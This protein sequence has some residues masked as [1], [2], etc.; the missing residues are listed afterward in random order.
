MVTLK[1]ADNSYTRVT[2]TDSIGRFFFNNGNNV[3]SSII[4]THIGY[5]PYEW[6]FVLS[7]DTTFAV[8]LKQ[9]VKQLSEVR[10]A[11]TRAAIER[12]ADKVVYNLGSS[13]IA[14]G[15]NAFQA[16]SQ[17]SGVQVSN[18]EIS[19][20]GRGV[21]RVM[22]NNRLIQLQGEDL[23][24]YLKS[25]SANQV[26]RIE[27]LTNPSARYEV[28]GNAGLINI[29]TKQSKLQGY[30]G[31]VQL[32]SKYYQSGQS[33]VYGIQTF[34]EFSGSANLAY[35]WNRWSA[36][37]SF[38]HVRDRHLEG[39]QFDLFY[40]KQHWLQTDTGLYTH[41][42]YTAL[43][44][45]DYKLS[46]KAAI[47]AYY[48]GGRDMYDGSDN[49][50]NPIYNSFG[51]VDS[52][53]KTY[54]HYH[55]IA[56]P[57]ALNL[58]ADVKLDTTGKH[59]FINADYF[60]YYRND[61]S[62]FESNSYDAAGNQ[63]SD[64][65]TLYFDRNKQNILIYT[66]KA[67]MEWPTAFATYSFGG[68]L[69]YIAE[70]SNAL[71]YNKTGAVGRVFNTNLSN[72]FSYT[73]NTQSF[74]GSLNKE[75]NKWKLQGGIRGEITQTKGYSYT[76]QKTTIN[77]YVKVF[78]SLLAGYTANPDNILSLVV[79]RRI[80]RPAFWN[81]NPFKSLFTA[82]SYGE[83]NPYLQPEYATNL[84]LSHA[85]KNI[86]RTSLFANKTGNGFVNVTIPHPDTNLVYTIPL[87][88]IRTVRIGITENVTFKLSRWWE[89]SA[90]VSVYHTSAHSSLSNIRSLKG[91]SA[92]FSSTNNLYFNQSK[93]FAAAINFWYQF[94]EVDHIGKTDR[95]YKMDVGFKATTANRKWDIAANL[96]D[97]FRSSAL[98]YSY[99]VNNI[100]QKFTNF[101]IIRYFQ[102]SL[103]YRFGSGSGSSTD[104]NAGN[105][106]E[107]A[108]V[109]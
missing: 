7:H 58:H 60:N 94:P 44:G 57:A 5:E 90:M 26:V 72:E 39:F 61:I 21:V 34:G 52:L 62:D 32:A 23:S 82:Y 78:P 86:L 48:S 9:S 91:E 65:K 88:F 74:Y 89:S 102:L 12:T 45:V 1:E 18:N 84:E 107:R 81:L 10:V 6:P 22:L 40:P 20:V 106:E 56:L 33:S 63:K 46:S 66:L 24:R 16:I 54:A 51:V 42:A 77:H 68:K 49:V 95:Y 67:D 96:N 17:V 53:L 98:A 55:P 19:V 69:S 29:I 15:S 31:N 76:I 97:A 35:N 70:Y 37:G 3:A 80:N 105:E 27:L 36:Y 75:V 47:G 2:Q 100:A 38:N 30:S 99:T 104:R 59:L 103:T 4:I 43:I 71:Y 8:H 64:G 28:E 11:G 25:F 50:R 41:N 101:Q 79:G 83:G 85:Y 109:H 87:N 108:R 92:Y 73:E 13:V 14:A 93:T